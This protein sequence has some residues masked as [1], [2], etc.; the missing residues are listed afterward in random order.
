M[1]R[2]AVL[3]ATLSSFDIYG[4]SSEDAAPVIPI[5]RKSIPAVVVSDK[6]GR[7]RFA[8]DFC[9]DHGPT[10]DGLP[11][12]KFS[13]LPGKGRGIKQP[14][15]KRILVQS[16]LE[17]GRPLFIIG[18]LVIGLMGFNRIILHGNHGVHLLR[19]THSVPESTGGVSDG[20][21][22][23]SPSPVRCT[24]RLVTNRVTRVSTCIHPDKRVTKK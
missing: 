14:S 23:P 19:S 9:A 8:G 16:A 11:C 20:G 3:T 22:H 15:V 2:D 4:E 17:L 18:L 12:S 1:G 13:H 24:G 5:K 6:S 7:A 10:D 21:K